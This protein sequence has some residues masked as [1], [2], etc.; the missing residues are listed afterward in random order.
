[1]QEHA[2]PDLAF[3][4]AS[5][6]STATDDLVRSFREGA[7]EPSFRPARDEASALLRR[8][9]EA[10]VVSAKMVALSREGR[11]GGHASSIGL[12]GVLAGAVVATRDTD[13]IFPSVRDGHAALAR[14]LPL[15]TYVHHAF[16]SAEDPTKG[17]SA[18]DHVPA[19]GLGVVPPSGVV[20][21]HLAQAVGAAW[22]AKIK[23]ESV[24]MLALFDADVADGGDFHNALNFAG[25]IKAPVVFVCRAPGAARVAD[26]AVAYGLASARVDGTDALAVVAVVKAAL[27]RANEGRGATLVE[28]V[29]PPVEGMDTLAVQRLETDAV[30]D[31]GADDPIP[32]LRRA[33]VNERLV[34]AATEAGFV[35]SLRAALDAAVAEAERVGPP[36]PA[37]IFEHVYAGVP[38]HL[39]AQRQKLTGG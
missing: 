26:R 35:A 37:T 24:S 21:A 12:E 2:A 27:A 28:A 14:G 39:A 11:I 19:R 7:L 8:M 10:R 23:Q 9:V 16:G 6:A 36:S 29:V 1:M 22:A 17:H 32:R 31:L 30:L 20:G 4:P 18:P 3:A 13:W 25:V 5:I 38:A 34:D 33:L 15:A